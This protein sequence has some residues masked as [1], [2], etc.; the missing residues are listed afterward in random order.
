MHVVS[1]YYV[2][3]VYVCLGRYVTSTPVEVKGPRIQTQHQ[4]LYHEPSILLSGVGHLEGL[5]HALLE[6][7][8]TLR[9]IYSSIFFFLELAL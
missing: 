1:Y 4:G 9:L 2:S 7:S 5:G 8:L 6:E 3:L